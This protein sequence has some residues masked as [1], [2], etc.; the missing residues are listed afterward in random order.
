MKIL[1][2]QEH[3]SSELMMNDMFEYLFSDIITESSKIPTNIE[4]I[5][6][7]LSKDLKFNYGLVLTFGVGVRAMFPIIENLI[8]NSNINIELTTENVVLITL[9]TISITYLEESGNKTGI[10]KI[11]C[12]KCKSKGCGDCTNGFT[13][14]KVS[15][16]DTNTILEE[17]KLR[18]VGNGII[19]KLVECFK[20]IGNIAKILFRNSKYIINGLMNM[21]AYTAI[22]LPTM[23]AISFLIGKYDLTIDTLIG[24]FLSLGVGITTFIAKNGINYLINKFKDRFELPIDKKEVLGDKTEVD[25]M[26]NHQLIKEQ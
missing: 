17:L 19:K 14:S 12:S 5:L 26:N 8:K 25:K 3:S 7:S 21:L 6:K 1:K 10:E 11:P 13:I 2:Y 23:N 4:K 16:S 9:A 24:N 18:G 20:S 22:L 15:K